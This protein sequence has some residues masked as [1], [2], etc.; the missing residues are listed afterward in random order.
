MVKG[1]FSLKFAEQITIVNFHFRT[2]MPKVEL[3][4]QANFTGIATLEV[5]KYESK[6]PCVLAGADPVHSDHLYPYRH[7]A[8]RQWASIGPLLDT[9]TALFAA[10]AHCTGKEQHAESL[11]ECG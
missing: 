2:E 9:R 6:Q 5:K 11:C 1:I 7:S 4:G 8:L 10:P 3:A